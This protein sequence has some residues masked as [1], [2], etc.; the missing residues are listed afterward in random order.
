MEVQSPDTMLSDEALNPAGSSVQI[1]DAFLGTND[2]V[3]I[4][5]NVRNFQLPLR[6]EPIPGRGTP[7]VHDKRGLRLIPEIQLVPGYLTHLVGPAW[8]LSGVDTFVV[9]LHYNSPL[10][11]ALTFRIR[12]TVSDTMASADALRLAATRPSQQI[13]SH[14]YSAGR[15]TLYLNLERLNFNGLHN[16]IFRNITGD[17]N[18]Q[19]CF[20]DRCAVDSSLWNGAS[21]LVVAAH[22]GSHNMIIPVV[23]DS[24]SLP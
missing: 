5:L 3:N 15:D 19:L 20:T 17:P 11:S 4:L 14:T 6:D 9:A 21:A 2:S 12:P 16:H 1:V 22:D 24:I 13:L 23:K 8:A 10:G 18:Y 7:M